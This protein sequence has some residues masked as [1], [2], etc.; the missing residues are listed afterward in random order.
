MISKTTLSVSEPLN[1]GKL[2][3]LLDI[4]AV[5][6]PLLVIGAIGTWLGA[7]TLASAGLITLGYVLSITVASV[8]LKLR[9]VGWREIGLARPQSWPR[10]ALLG[11][12]AWLVSIVVTIAV[13]VIALNLPGLAAEPA[14]VSRFNPLAGNLP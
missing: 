5:L 11:V 2:G 10:T 7:G 12:G 13:Q 3:G 14:D 6:L 8:V 1:G 4:V 9:G